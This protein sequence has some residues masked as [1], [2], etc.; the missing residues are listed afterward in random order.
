MCKLQ[1]VRNVCIARAFSH[2]NVVREKHSITKITC[3]YMTKSIIFN[4]LNKP[5]R[6]GLMNLDELVAEIKRS[7]IS[8]FYGAGVAITCGGPS[9]GELFSDIKSRFPEG[10]SDEFFTYMDEI[11]G[12]DDS[13]RAEVEE[14][15]RTRL[16]SISPQE[17]H[18]YLFSIPWRAVLTTNYDYL[19]EAINTTIDERRQIIAISD[20]KEQ[21]DQTREDHL[22]CFKLLGDCRYNFLEGGWMVLSTSDLFSAAQRRTRFFEQFRNLATSGH[23]VYL[24]YSFRDDLVF[25]LLKQMKT[26]LRRFPWKGFAIMPSEPEADIKKKMELVGI[27]WV[28]GDLKD[29]ITATKKVLGK[30]PTSAPTGIG[31]LTVHRQTIELDRSILSNIWKKFFVLHNDLLKYSFETPK[32]FLRGICP[33][34]YPYVLNWDFPRK[35][36]KVFTNPNTK[37]STPDDLTQLKKQATSGELS[38]NV[39]VAL[40]GIAGSGK[41][42]VANRLAFEWYQIGNPVI[43]IN[44][45]SLSIDTAALDGLMNEIRNKYLSKAH[46]AGIKEPY[47]LRW[48]IVA[49]GCGP[50]LGELR[51]L[52]NHLLA[53]AKPAD[54][55]LVARET[56]TPIDKLIKYELDAVYRLDDTVLPREREDFLK[57][58]KRFGVMNEDIVKKNIRDREINRSFFAL[59]YSSIQD[60]RQTIRKL[61][62]EEYESLDAESKRIYRIAALVQSYQLRPWLSLILKSLDE[63]PD[64]VN[65]QVEQGRLGGVLRFC[66]Y[67]HT[68][69]TPHRVIAEAISDIAFRTSEERKIAL[70]KIISAVTL[71]DTSEMDFLHNLLIGRIEEDIGPKFLMDHKIDLFR[72]A[73]QM[74]RTRPLLIHLG[75]LETNAEKFSDAMKSLKEAYGA[76]VPGFHEREEHVR[77]AEGRLEHTIAETKIISGDME[78]AWDHLEKAEEKFAEATIDPKI[79]PHPYEGIART[80]LTK[81]RIS[82][83]A[84]IQWQFILAAMQE[85]NYVEKY[86]GETPEISLLKKEIEARLARIGFNETHI[87]KIQNRIGKAN[88]YAYLAENKIAR[89]QFKQALELVDKGLKFDGMNIWLMRL[90]VAL[91]RKLSPDDH[92][93]IMATL[94]D[95]AAV[96]SER[97]DIELSFELAKETYM[98]GRIREAR[99]RFR[100]LYRKASHHPRRLIPRDPEDRWLEKGKPVRLRGTITKVPTEDRYGYVQTTFPETFKGTMVVRKKDIQYENVKAGDRVSYEV[101]FNMYGPEAS[102]VRSL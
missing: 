102:R 26:V 48:L 55:L 16:A 90:R 73:V 51:M 29:F 52:K 27:T 32:D 101:I 68:L 100:T 67:G 18:R 96:S 3:I 98:L 85:C 34:F 76:H 6:W 13:N 64:W 17:D 43:F 30:C 66:D 21:I 22:Y 14:F 70:S 35:T 28:K 83:E 88:G 92:D 78:S 8:L 7:P 56:E 53:V 54:L 39:F 58:F 31:F 59:V 57:H 86:L 62:Q 10:K 45:E 60:S 50:I 23:I 91:L 9:W 94:D 5:I 2:K 89:R 47:P 97:Y 36:E 99:W 44:S 20:P 63:D 69:M 81:A 24:G 25:L 72:Q 93:A 79:T 46:E 71:G 4:G 42:V 65:R 74:A 15:V 87:E 1:T 41:T 84:N 38:D 19:P 80:Y 82:K 40:V 12:F 61:L 37:A 77:D 33:S 11:I 95:Y 49:D 75:R